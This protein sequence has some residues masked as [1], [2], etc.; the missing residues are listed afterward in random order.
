[1][2]LK[3]IIFLTNSESKIW[4]S[5]DFFDILTNKLFFSDLL[6]ILFYLQTFPDTVRPNEIS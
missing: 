5:I 3:H 1:M 6:D 2:H 4:Q